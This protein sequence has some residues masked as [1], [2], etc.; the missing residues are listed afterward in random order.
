MM[1]KENYVRPTVEVVKMM[2]ELCAG[3]T[4]GSGGS[5][6]QG[7]PKRK[8]FSDDGSFFVGGMFEHG[9]ASASTEESS[10]E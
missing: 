5:E 4:T 10:Y 1:E 8:S 9:Q 7:A 2:D 3:I 6:E